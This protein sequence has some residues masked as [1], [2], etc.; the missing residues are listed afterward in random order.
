M[1]PGSAREFRLPERLQQSTE[2]ATV[3]A[4]RTL[5]NRYCVLLK[6]AIGWKDNFE[7][8]LCCNK[9]LRTEE[10]LHP[11][12]GRPYISLEGFYPFE[13]LYLRKERGGGRYDVFFDLN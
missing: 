4:L 9:P 2:Q 1:P 5:D 10:V 12:G 3:H 8:A 11:P 7:G 6:T 13:E